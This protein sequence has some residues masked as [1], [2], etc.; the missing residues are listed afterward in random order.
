VKLVVFLRDEI[1][2]L[3][4]FQNNVQNENYV[5]QLKKMDF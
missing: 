3:I 5:I 1:E 2:E 4:R